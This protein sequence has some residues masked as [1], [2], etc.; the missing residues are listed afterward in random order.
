MASLASAL[1]RS[2]NYRSPVK[3][4]V[5]AVT[6]DLHYEH[7]G[8]EVT[9]RTAALAQGPTSM[10]ATIYPP[11]FPRFAVDENITI[12]NYSI[13]SG[14]MTVRSNA[15]IHNTSDVPVD[16]E[17]YSRAYQIVYPPSNQHTVATLTTAA[18]GTLI[19]MIGTI[20]NVSHYY[21]LQIFISP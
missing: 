21:A 20:T 12:S 17:A 2:T 6:Q 16:D 8:Q 1:G 9:Y 11:H 7:N 15:R 10:K 14:N 13:A 19:T 4:K 3:C 18:P 5:V